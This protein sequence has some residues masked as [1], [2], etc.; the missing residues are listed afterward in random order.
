MTKTTD[1][2]ARPRNNEHD[3]QKS[4]REGRPPRP[5]TEPDGSAWST[6]T[7]RTQSDPGSGETAPGRRNS[8]SGAKAR[9]TLPNRLP[10]TP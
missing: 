3:S 8:Q 2:A 1:D 9:S 5:A 4:G 7:P 6:R 10:V